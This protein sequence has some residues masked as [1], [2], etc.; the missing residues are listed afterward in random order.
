MLQ[1]DE[2]FT[3]KFRA[4][5]HVDTRP[6]PTKMSHHCPFCRSAENQGVC[7]NDSLCSKIS[8]LNPC[9]PCRR[10]AEL[11]IQII[12]ARETVREMQREAQRLKS[13]MNCSHDH[14]IHRLPPEISSNIFQLC[15]SREPSVDARYTQVALSSVC[16]KW[17]QIAHTTPQLWT[18]VFL[19]LTQRNALSVPS[20][21]QEWIDRSGQLPLSIGLFVKR[22]G[23]RDY[24]I[25]RDVIAVINK[26]SSRWRDLTYQGPP[27]S[28]TYLVGDSQGASQLQTLKLHI[29][30]Y[31]RA[32]QFKLGDFR[33]TP[34]TLEISEVDLK[35][36]IIEWNNITHVQAGGFTIDECWELFRIAPQMT[37]CVLLAFLT[38][39]GP[40][41]SLTYL[42]GDSQGASQLQTLKLHISR[43]ERASQFKL[44]DFRPTPT[45]L[46]ISEVDLK[47]VIIEW[48]NIT[49]V[50]AGGFTIDE[51][52]E[53]F[54]IAPQMTHCVLLAVRKPHDQVPMPHTPILHPTLQVLELDRVCHLFSDHVSLPS[55]Q[56]YTCHVDG[57]HFETESLIS[58]SLRSSCSLQT[59][60]LSGVKFDVADLVKLSRVTPDLRHLDLALY[61]EY[62][63]DV[64]VMERIF[65]RFS[66]AFSITSTD[67]E[68]NHAFF[69][70]LQSMAF[71]GVMP[72]D[73][74]L[75]LDIFGSPSDLQNLHRRPL[76]ALTLSST[77]SQQKN[78]IDKDTLS[79]MLLLIAQGIELKIQQE[80][81]GIDIL[82][83]SIEFHA[84]RE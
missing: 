21:A 79:R 37:H 56:S 35:S 83:Q 10:L 24:Y 54:R 69:P 38:Y 62:G 50:Q 29:S 2:A 5:V 15:V 1:S 23:N 70:Q 42:V 32:S 55:L 12:K 4:A 14:L 39:Q 20:W 80:Y 67:S 78:P 57:G 64:N 61:Y 17:R 31:E 52:W 76:R 73:Y 18:T 71:T 46:E 84:R 16:Q 72:L 60:V 65:H 13:D 26:C 7:D 36:V 11:D 81:Y 33:P 47:S 19:L 63:A 44:G 22:E 51:C 25:N 53:L 77:K 58:L 30:R 6:Q 27:S 8:N 34:T 3:S 66:N 48:N 40:P 45:T 68:T 59:L 49:H 28:L 82:Q 41:S 74:K 75:V 43:Y 9:D